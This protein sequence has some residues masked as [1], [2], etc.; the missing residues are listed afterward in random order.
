MT[1]LRFLTIFFLIIVCSPIK[2]EINITGA[3]RTDT[4]VHAYNQV[5][6]VK[7]PD[8]LDLKN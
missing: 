8:N 5:A 3:S 1:I 4:G 6:S 7:L 2:A